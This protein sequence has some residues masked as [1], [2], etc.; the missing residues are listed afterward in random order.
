[1]KVKKNEWKCF[2]RNVFF[3]AAWILPFSFQLQQNYVVSVEMEHHLFQTFV[4][5]TIFFDLEYYFHN[6]QSQA[7]LLIWVKHGRLH[8][9]IR[10]TIFIHPLIS[11]IFV[12]FNFLHFFNRKFSTQTKP[13]YG[14]KSGLKKRMVVSVRQQKKRRVFMLYFCYRASATN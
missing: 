2:F 9:F 12:L 3:F 5:H 13:N 11:I 7:N 14:K 4:W 8:S 10:N 6:A 1:M